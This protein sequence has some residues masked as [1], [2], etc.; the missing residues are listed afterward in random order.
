MS[1]EQ[2]RLQRG[3][4][5]GQHRNGIAVESPLVRRSSTLAGRKPLYAV[6]ATARSRP[7]SI[8]SHEGM[9]S[10][11]STTGWLSSGKREGASA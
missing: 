9:R 4:I 10:A 8:H 5:A 11:V 6:R 1:L 2:E 3:A 7:F